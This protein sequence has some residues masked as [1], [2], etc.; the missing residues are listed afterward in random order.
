MSKKRHLRICVVFTAANLAG[1]AVP[2]FDVPYDKTGSPTAYSIVKRIECEL[3]DLVRKDENG[4]YIYQQAPFLINEDYDAAAIISLEVND[5]GG[6]TPA[7]SAISPF[8]AATSFAFSAGGTLQEA[9]DQT[10]TENLYFSMSTFISNLKRDPEAY[11]CVPTDTNLSGNLGIKNI[12]DLASR[13]PYTDSTQTLTGGKGVFGGTVQF[14]VTEGISATGPTWTLTHFT[15]PGGLVG[16]S[17][18]NT[19]KLTIAFGPAPA[20][21]TGQPN[22]NGKKNRGN[23]ELENF[24]QQLVLLQVGS[25]I[26]QLQNSLH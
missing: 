6:L 17:H 16:L 19:D 23:L 26:L 2:A 18:V 15:G 25:Q 21:P 10:F 1:C 14:T 7:V 11:Q 4:T 13:S 22:Q 3:A 12:V 8:T 9:R 5:T 20:Q 24:L